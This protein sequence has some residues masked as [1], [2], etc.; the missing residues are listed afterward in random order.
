MGDRLSRT[1][2]ILHRSALLRGEPDARAR[3]THLRVAAALDRPGWCPPL[4]GAVTALFA[5]V[6][7][8]ADRGPALV[9]TLAADPPL[10]RAIVDRKSV[11]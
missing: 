2:S 5:Q 11:V 7:A 1:P 3:P 9:A 6:A 4:A 10:A 8:G